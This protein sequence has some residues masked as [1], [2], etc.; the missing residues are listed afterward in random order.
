M[1]QILCVFLAALLFF[2]PINNLK[3]NANNADEK[4]DA[5][6]EMTKEEL[7]LKVKKIFNIEDSFEEFEIDERKSEMGR[8]Y[9]LN[10]NDSLKNIS[11]YVNISSK[12]D[13]LSYEKIYNNNNDNKFILPEFDFKEAKLKAESKL[14]EILQDEFKNFKL[15]ETDITG[16]NRYTGLYTLIYQR[17]V[18]SVLVNGEGIKIAID[19][20]T[21]EIMSY[22]LNMALSYYLKDKSMFQNKAQIIS[23]EEALEKYKKYNGLYLNLHRIL[24]YSSNSLYP[25]IKYIPVYTRA[26]DS[27]YIDAKTGKPK[28]IYDTFAFGAGVDKM[29]KEESAS[30]LTGVEREELKKADVKVDV[31]EAEKICRDI[32]K[33]S[34]KMK[35]VSSRLEKYNNDADKFSWTLKFSDDNS[36]Y[37]SVTIDANDKTLIL[38][39]RDTEME[40]DKSP[41]LEEA[42]KVSESFLKLRAKDILDNLELTPLSYELQTKEQKDLRYIRKLND[43]FYILE[44]GIN[45]SLGGSD[46]EIKYFNRTW[47]DKIQVPA[48]KEL[49]PEEAYEILLDKYDFD[50]V[51]TTDYETRKYNLMYSFIKEDEAVL[52]DAQSGEFLDSFGN[53]ISIKKSGYTDIDKAK[54]KKKIQLLSDYNI[55]FLESELKPNETIKQKDFM[56]LLYAIDRGVFSESIDFDEVYKH[57]ENIKLIHKDEIDKEK[58]LN[59]IDLAKFIIRKKGLEDVA[60]LEHIFKDVYQDANRNGYLI[61]AGKLGLIKASGEKI[62]PDKEVTREEALMIIYNY[63]FDK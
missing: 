35:L 4:L 63:L 54:D 6:S 1:K 57:L 21:G 14:K 27:I 61:L 52:I 30:N 62:L 36:K 38:M 34:N 48:I 44:D 53:P 47:Y 37:I 40:A 12:G 19:S 46:A 58:L 17:Y 23:R 8:S 26:Y 42:I 29:L 55:R 31:E 22:N 15:V 5:S 49:K 45:L 28:K 3:A 24:D 25:I 32:A 50:L 2:A 41:K 18:N 56:L 11:I 13:I 60:K 20:K 16:L 51:Y 39:Q 10:W 43:K 59:R 7:I 33:L 9:F